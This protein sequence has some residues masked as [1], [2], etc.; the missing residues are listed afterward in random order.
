VKQD[1]AFKSSYSDVD[2]SVP[3]GFRS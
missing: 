3:A 1:T 2:Y